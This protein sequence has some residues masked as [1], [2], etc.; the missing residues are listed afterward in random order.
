ML[1]TWVLNRQKICNLR[2]K[3]NYLN[4]SV[5]VRTE[6]NVNLLLYRCNF[7]CKFRFIF[8]LILSDNAPNPHFREAKL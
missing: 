7:H 8:S 4:I 1:R 2:L 5:T 6:T 3:T